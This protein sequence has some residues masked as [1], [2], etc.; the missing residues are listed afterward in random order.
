MFLRLPQPLNAKSPIDFTPFCN[1]TDKIP[2]QLAKAYSPTE[3]VL[4]GIIT[5]VKLSQNKK[6]PFLIA[7]TPSGMVTDVKLVQYINVSSS[8]EVMPSG[9]FIVVNPRQLAKAFLPI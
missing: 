2:V 4:L 6:A 7:V 9:I 3:A 8:I 5:D 1:F